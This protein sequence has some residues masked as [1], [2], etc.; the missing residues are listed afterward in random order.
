MMSDAYVETTILTDILLKPQTPKQKR[1]KAALARYENTLLPVYSIKEWKAGPLSHFAYL[2]DKLVLTQSLA[3]TIQAIA[4]LPRLG[5]RRATST[6]ALAAAGQ[7]AKKQTRKYAALGTTDEENADSYRLALVSIIIRSWQKRRKVTSH[8]IQDLP[9]YLEAAPRVGKDGL[10]EFEP[11]LC[12]G[13]QECC[14]A[15]ELKSKP[16]LLEKLRGAIPKNSTRREDEKRRQAL[17]QLIK[18]PKEVV[19]RETCRD[20]GDA[21]FAFFC[22]NNAVILTTNIKD[23][24]PLA[25]AIGKKAEKP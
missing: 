21:I 17:K 2:H 22:P 24:E 18:H 11:R 10:F 5:Y 16:E 19:T 15:S 3:D 9:C 12:D 23:H 13:E 1:A 8:V 6:E 25:T 4:A 14:L 7:V 20:L